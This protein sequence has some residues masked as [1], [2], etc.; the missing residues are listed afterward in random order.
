MSGL[1]RF[2][3]SF[4]RRRYLAKFVVSILAVVLVIGLVGAASYGQVN[5]TVRTDATDQ[6]E[7]TAEMQAGTIGDWVETM[8]VQTRSISAAQPLVEGET[9]AVQ[10]QLVESQARM[11]VAVRAIHYVDTDSGEIVTS[12]DADRRGQALSA[13]DEPWADLGFVDSFTLDDDVWHSPQSY[14]ADVLDDQVM[15]F[16]SPVRDR[17]D[18]IAVV[19][20]ALEY[21]LQELEQPST[22]ATTTVFDADGTP[23][24]AGDNRSVDAA[25]IDDESLAAAMGG[26]PTIHE[27]DEDVYAYVPI[28]DTPWVAVTTV[29]TEA[30]YGVANSV[31]D[32]F[33]LTVLVSLLALGV[34]G[35]VLGRQTVLPL[36][37]L[38]DRAAA[39]EGGDLD[40]DLETDRVDEIGR[41]YEGFDAM[42]TSLK[43]RIEEAT[44]AR[45]EAEEARAETAEINRHLE[46]TAAEYGDVM[47]DCADGDL[48]RRLEPDS[49]HE[50]M[51]QIATSFNRMVADLETTTARAQAFADVVDR[52]SRSVDGSA[53]EVKTASAQ[54]SESIQEISDGA[55]RQ[56]E[57]LQTVVGEMESL[58]TTTEE[59][60][61]ASNEVADVAERTAETGQDGREAAQLAIDG[62]ADVQADA[63][64]A[65]EAIEALEAEIEQ[66]DDLVTFISD[67][68]H[69]TNMLALNANIEASREADEAGDDGGFAVV[70]EEIKEL[71]AETKEATTDIEERIERITERTDE[72]AGQ[73]ERTA[74][75]IE[76]HVD[77]VENAAGALEEIAAYATETNDGVQ[78]I[79]AAT[80]QQAAT[81][82]EV[83]S[84]AASATEIA[85]QTAAESEQVAAAAEE[86]TSA[87]TAVSHRADGLSVQA[88]RLS[89]ALDGFE[90]DV[91]P[92]VE[93]EFVEFVAADEADSESG[94]PVWEDDR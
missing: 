41:L 9:Q 5:E 70:A 91:E 74:E 42:R 31:G 69:E 26:R 33:V 3:P 84:M 62:M 44:E 61:A 28:A 59:I 7:R 43:R 73:V 36:A 54:M 13:V 81:T 18:R 80:E 8:G 82:E 25:A 23:V 2:V 58:S 45:R 24:L 49:D 60:A 79:S 10:A 76:E 16:A 53:R 88:E 90:T 68:A 87:V 20:G 29:P 85:D 1:A 14:R 4:V 52:A 51:A 94:L 39:M 89:D 35:V 56:H 6:L 64:A 55:D 37:A 65:V 19:I 15:A 86:Q 63:D 46:A 21:R 78:E 48:T 40:V 30:A 22:D 11:S 93:T 47:A 92:A 66:I 77:S 34:M 17:D 71:A 72:T 27:T 75:R 38:R 50:A 12:T 67:V 57:H 83:V 32:S